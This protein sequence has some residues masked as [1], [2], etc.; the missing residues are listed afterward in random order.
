MNRTSSSIVRET[1]MLPCQVCWRVSPGNDHKKYCR[2]C[3]S[4]LQPPTVEGAAASVAGAFSVL[5]LPLGFSIAGRYQIL[6]KLGDGGMGVVYEAFDSAMD[7]KV[8]LKLLLPKSR[9]DP[10]SSKR[11]RRE[12][13]AT[14][15]IAHPNVIRLYDF[16]EVPLE[17]RMFAYYTMEKLVGR[18]LAETIEARGLFPVEDAIDVLK[19]L[20]AALRAVHEAGV[21]HR[22][23]KPRNVFIEESGRVRLVDF[24]LA[25][26]SDLGRFTKAGCFIGTPAYMSPEQIR[27][28]EEPD[29]RS[30]LY[31]LGV[32]AYELLTGRVPFSGARM[33]EVARKHF[34]ERPHPP[35]ALRG[36]IPA[37]LN[38]LI[39]HLLAKAPADRPV[40]AA[41][42]LARI[43]RCH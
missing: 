25:I 34:N 10:D 3:G 24:G 8:A 2:R 15:K 18:D 5:N 22:D 11:F 1:K 26:S 21:V 36:E 6:R 37:W 38:Q 40:S 7:E 42:V 20:C 17:G 29:R 4:P 23:L 30:D 19:Q 31:S 27:A 28:T 9:Q 43:E 12:V 41:E 32:L 13:K 14:R 16:G 39:L 33:I 35:S